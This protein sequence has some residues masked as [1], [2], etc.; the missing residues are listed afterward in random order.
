MSVHEQFAEDLS[1]YALEAL[2][3][4]ERRVLEE[5]LQGCAECRDE[6]ELMRGDLGLLGLSASG[7]EPPARSRQRLLDAV[8]QE[9][10]GARLVRSGR[11]SGWWQVLEWA[12]GAAAVVVMLLLVRE[13]TS[14]QR[15]IAGLEAD[16]E[17][18]QAQLAQAKELMAS[19]TS[20][21]AEHFILVA[22]KTPPQPQG[23]ALYVRGS[24]MLVFLASNM[25]PLPPERIYELWLIPSTG[26][27]IPAGLFKPGPGGD[28]TVV[29]PAL[30]AGVEAKAFAITVEP[31][32]GS[33]APTSA[34]IMAGARS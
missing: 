22:G 4:E 7:A 20:A 3:S 31:E 24:G 34:P 25:P 18:Q 10:R 30:P 17:A 14:L 28:A 8:A 2:G 21:D 23:K 11:K 15:R 26:A 16:S 32:G 5:H 19:L 27:P 1:L 33:A 9:P 12:A 6:L 29:K 13:N